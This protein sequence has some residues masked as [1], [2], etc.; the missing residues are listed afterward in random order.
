MAYDRSGLVGEAYD[1]AMD[2]AMNADRY[3]GFTYEHVTWNEFGGEAS[4]AE[5]GMNAWDMVVN[6]Y[7]AF[8]GILHA[9]HL[10]LF[11]HGN[12]LHCLQ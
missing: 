10:I 12:G 5:A 2:F 11:V 6:C 1:E 3:F 4:A 7:H 8:G 9:G